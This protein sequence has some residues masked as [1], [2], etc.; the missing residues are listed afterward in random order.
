[1][2]EV[3]AVQII[4][5]SLKQQVRG[6]PGRPA[7]CPTF[8]HCTFLHLGYCPT[9]IYAICGTGAAESVALA[10]TMEWSLILRHLFVVQSSK[11]LGNCKCGCC[12]FAGE[13]GPRLLRL[14]KDGADLI[15]TMFQRFGTTTQTHWCLQ[16]RLSPGG[17]LKS[18]IL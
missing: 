7:I 14:I 17:R 15:K 11:T 18:I 1:M 6:S 9:T 5:E 4:A 3:E 13:N 8:W 16:L 2:A 12:C 10:R